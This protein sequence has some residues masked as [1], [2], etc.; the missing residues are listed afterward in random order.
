MPHL[1]VFVES[2]HTLVSGVTAPLRNG[3][4][5][6]PCSFG[7][8]Y[9]RSRCCLEVKDYVLVASAVPGCRESC[10]SSLGARCG[11]WHNSDKRG[12]YQPDTIGR[13]CSSTSITMPRA[14]RTYNSLH[15][16]AHALS[17]QAAPGCF[18]MDVKSSYQSDTPSTQVALAASCGRCCM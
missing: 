4:P 7:S 16:S 12:F 9:L 3:G 17:A 18:L 2:M 11:N 5:A 13:A 15:C 6:N 8:M 1:Y 10:F 14:C